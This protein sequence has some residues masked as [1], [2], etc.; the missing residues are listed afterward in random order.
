[1]E[2]KA[3]SKETGAHGCFIFVGDN[4]T[5]FMDGLLFALA[6][7]YEK[8]KNHQRKMYFITVGVLLWAD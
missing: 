2:C 6:P 1:M 8:L 7:K 5:K 4:L 3:T